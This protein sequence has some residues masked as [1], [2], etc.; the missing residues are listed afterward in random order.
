MRETEWECFLDRRAVCNTNTSIWHVHGRKKK[1]KNWNVFLD[2]FPPLPLFLLVWFQRNWLQYQHSWLITRL[3]FY[4]NSAFCFDLPFSLNT[5]M[6][7]SPQESHRTNNTHCS[8]F[9]T[10]GKGSYVLCS[11]ALFTAV[12]PLPSCR[13]FWWFWEKLRGIPII[14][15]HPLLFVGFSVS[16]SSSSYQIQA[17]TS[18]I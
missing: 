6:N 8:L 5:V 11:T 15:P 7:V 3:S 12:S 18:S 14:P 9:N 10:F 2:A 1:K 16:C 13:L 17:L 4:V